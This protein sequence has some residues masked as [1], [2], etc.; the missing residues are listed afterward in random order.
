[1]HGYHGGRPSPQQRKEI[2]PG[3]SVRSRRHDQHHRAGH[4]EVG[5]RPWVTRASCY[6]H[7]GAGHSPPVGRAAPARKQRNV[8]PEAQGPSALDG[9]ARRH[10]IDTLAD[11]RV[12]LNEGAVGGAG[13]QSH[14]SEFVGDVLRG[15]AE[16]GARRVPTTHGIVGDHPDP[17]HEI[18]SSDRADGVR[19]AV[20]R[21]HR[22]G[23]TQ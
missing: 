8:L 1:M 22:L 10:D 16:P 14:P 5:N 9:D 17:S 12:L 23:G 20:L 2:A 15:H 11:Q 6:H 4:V 13:R 18:F 7:R 3:P 19:H 21:Q